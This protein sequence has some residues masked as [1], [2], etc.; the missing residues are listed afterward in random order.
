MGRP[1]HWLPG[2]GEF[3][4]PFFFLWPPPKLKRLRYGLG[5]SG[6]HPQMV[7]SHL[8]HQ[9]ERCKSAESRIDLLH[10]ASPRYCDADETR[11]WSRLSKSK[12]ISS[13][14]GV[15]NI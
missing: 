4:S 3:T 8:I 1:A 2:V 11:D 13:R 15:D 6:F 12:M 10:G 7:C 9:C 14:L 5:S